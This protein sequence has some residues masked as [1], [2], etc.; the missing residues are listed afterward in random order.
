M[1]FIKELCPICG[2]AAESEKEHLIGERLVNLL[3]C[4]HILVKDQVSASRPPEDI[5][6]LDGKS[7]F[8][9]QCDGIRFLESSGARALIADE[10][11]LGKTAQASGFLCLHQELLPAVFIVK[12]SLKSQWQYELMR[13]IGDDMFVQIL[14]SSK[15][16]IIPGLKGYIFS[17]DALRRFKNLPEKFNELGIKTIVI[18]E[19]QQI[20]NVESQRTRE[21]RALCK[22]RDHVIALSGT[23]IKNNAA[24]YFPILNILKPELYSN[25]TRFTW[26]ECAT[27]FD[28]YKNKVGG[29]RDPKGFLEKTKHFIIRRE[30]KDVLPDLPQITRAFHF[31]DLGK[32]V[33]KEYAAAYDLFEHEMLDESLSAFEKSSN[34]LAYLSK[35]RHITGRSKVT[36]T[37]EFTADFLE[38]TDRKLTI[39]VH[40]KDVGE[41]LVKRISEIAYEQDGIIKSPKVLSLTA[42]L[43]SEDRAAIVYDFW[44]DPGA[45]VLVA[46]TLAAGEGLN[47]QNCSDCIILERQWNPANEEQAEGR[48][49]RI[50]QLSDKVTANYMVALGTVDEFFSELVERKREIVKKTLSGDAVAWDQSS[51]VKEL[52]ENLLARG[53]KKWIR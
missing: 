52:A 47:L 43:S 11:G 10:M 20:K 25:F 34:I 22:G 1:P 39:F 15:D 13:W 41:M 51:L 29:L 19:V 9:Y 26:N 8:K 46:S 18:D 42:D 3:K 2:K 38:Q 6:S 36:P 12:A 37:V 45:R 40:H 44:N 30:R 4:G 31:S 14:D 21:V 24:E 50:G 5:V 33:E 27:Y 49:I 23:P 28:G 16:F 48:F 17:F 35:M 7:L 53:K 32:E